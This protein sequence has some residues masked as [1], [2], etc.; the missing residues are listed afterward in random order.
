MIIQSDSMRM[1]SSRTYRQSSFHYSSLQFWNNTTGTTTAMNMSDSS[2]AA[3]NSNSLNTFLNSAYEAYNAAEAAKN[4]GENNTSAASAATGDTT[5]PANE[6]NYLFQHF[7][8]VQNVNKNGLQERI[9]ELEQIRQET[10]HYLLQRLFGKR[11]YTSGSYIINKAAASTSGNPAADTNTVPADTDSHTGGKYNSFYSY[12]EKE[13]TAFCTNGTVKT[14][15]GRELSFRVNVN[16]TRSFAESSSTEINFGEAN[17]IDPLV[18]NLKGNVASVSDQTFLFDLDTDGNAEEISILSPDSGYL[19]LDKNEDG[20]INDGSELFG[21]ASGNGFQD[22]AAYDEDGNGWIDE[23]DSVFQ[24]LRIWCM[25]ANGSSTLYTLAEAGVGALY[26]G[27]NSTEFSLKNALNE[28]Q[29]I[30]RQTGVFLY[31]NGEA[32]TLQQVDLAVKPTEDT[33]LLSS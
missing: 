30:I 12:S 20:V 21:T 4:N 6:T 23:A 15:D 2:A 5:N 33:S 8:S 11:Y 16:M 32:G 28:T 9:R 19:A 7:Q 26:L 1:N 24:K 10:L 17:T 29:A 3:Q 22:L 13:T 27:S 31:E 18:I 25:D 14:A